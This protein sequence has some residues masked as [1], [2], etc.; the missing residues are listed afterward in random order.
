MS[1]RKKRQKHRRLPSLAAI[2]LACIVTLP[3]A[4]CETRG[5]GDIIAEFEQENGQTFTTCETAQ[6]LGEAFE[7]CKPA[8]WDTSEHCRGL[9]DE[10]ASPTHQE[11]ALV[12]P[13]ETG[14]CWVAAFEHSWGSKSQAFSNVDF[15]WLRL[16]RCEQLSI[17]TDGCVVPS[18]CTQQ[19]SWNL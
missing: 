16:Y 2:T 19:K 1:S 10:D 12:V 18:V 5:I 14:G 9:T 13:S 17:S 6:C 3:A 11:A 15:N 8:K 4:G 7:A